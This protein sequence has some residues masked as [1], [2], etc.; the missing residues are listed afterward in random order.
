M[1]GGEEKNFKSTD[2]ASRKKQE[3]ANHEK[4]ANFES[5]E[6][7]KQEFEDRRAD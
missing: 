2:E 3:K 7:K 4:K 6:K 5:R 1:I